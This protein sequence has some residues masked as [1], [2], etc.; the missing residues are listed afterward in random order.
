MKLRYIKLCAAA[1]VALSLSVGLTACGDDEPD[2]VPSVTLAEGA[3]TNIQLTWSDNMIYGGVCFNASGDWAAEILPA[4]SKFEVTTESK[5]LSQVEWLEIAPY[6]GTFGSISAT[7]YA[8]PNH[9]NEARYAVI[10]V[11]SVGNTLDFHVTQQGMPS[12]SGNDTPV[13]P[14][15]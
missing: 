6:S 12:S 13:T 15:E 10:R 2:T 3:S 14:A 4:N 1:L 5:T 8:T 7:V 9:S 11:N